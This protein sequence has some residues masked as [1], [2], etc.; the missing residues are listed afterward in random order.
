MKVL[1][2]GHVYELENVDG[3]GVQ[4]LNFVQRRDLNAELLPL[5]QRREGIL[6][7]EVLR[8]AIDRTIYLHNEDAWHEN[9]IIINKLRDAL[10]MYE[11]RAAHKAITRLQMPERAPRCSSCGHFLCFC[12]HG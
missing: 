6:T 8:V 10:R 1:V 7:Q 12:N 2:P 3:D 4:Y 5:P 11:A 9:V